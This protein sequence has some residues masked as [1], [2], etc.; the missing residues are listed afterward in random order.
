MGV[1]QSWA[2]AGQA[3][4]SWVSGYPPSGNDLLHPTAT[5]MARPMQAAARI[6][7][8][9][10]RLAVAAQFGALS[11]QTFGGQ[12]KPY[13]ASTHLLRPLDRG[14]HPGSTLR[15]LLMLLRLLRSARCL[16]YGGAG[17]VCREAAQSRLLALQLSTY[18][19]WLCK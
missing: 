11:R 12:I 2:D 15:L 9:L 14:G 18:A 8:A 7:I 16:R 13:P 6:R 19:A 4:P 17:A 1:L 5:Y 10:A 3:V